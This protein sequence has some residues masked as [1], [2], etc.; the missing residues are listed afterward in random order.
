VGSVQAAVTKLIPD[1][2]GRDTFGHPADGEVG[3]GPGQ[4]EVKLLKTP[5]S[6]EPVGIAEPHSVKPLIV[7]DQVAMQVWSGA[8]QWPEAAYAAPERLAAWPGRV[9]A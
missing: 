1:E 2:Q 9:V 3:V 4:Q 6:F 5:H 7:S 8:A